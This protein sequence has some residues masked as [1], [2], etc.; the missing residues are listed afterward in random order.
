METKVISEQ[1]LKEAR[2]SKTQLK[3]LAKA[4]WNLVEKYDLSTPDVLIILGKSW[5]P[6]TIKKY[7]DSL[8]FPEG[9]TD[10]VLRASH[11]LSIHWSLRVLYPH[12]RSIVYSWIKTKAA[13]FNNKS[14]IQILKESGFKSL[15]SSHL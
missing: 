6:K 13:E 11:L 3:S 10:V 8:S 2:F 7:K 1:A 12:N 9:D 4:F 14:P 5:D 15:I